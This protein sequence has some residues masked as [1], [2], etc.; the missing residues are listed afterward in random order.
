MSVLIILITIACAVFNVAMLLPKLQQLYTEYAHIYQ[1][2]LCVPLVAS[3]VLNSVYL[4]LK[5]N[6]QKRTEPVHV[7]PV[8]VS[9][10]THIPT[11]THTI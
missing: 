10:H 11:H 5:R 8:Q 9:T 3:I 6:E 4:V 7:P 2:V 1:G